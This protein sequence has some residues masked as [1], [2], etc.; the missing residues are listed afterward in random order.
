MY[1]LLKR[2]VRLVILAIN[3]LL[4]RFVQ[5]V[6][7]GCGAILILFSIDFGADNSGLLLPGVLM[8]SLAFWL[9][10]RQKEDP[11]WGRMQFHPLQFLCSCVGWLFAWDGCLGLIEA[12]GSLLPPSGKLE[13]GWLWCVARACLG[14]L[15]ARAG[16]LF[17]D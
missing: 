11:G 14:L 8:V 17:T 9:V 2:L 10:D 3:A 15:I 13:T 12:V 1:A 4:M 16:V 5:S 7:L 6:F